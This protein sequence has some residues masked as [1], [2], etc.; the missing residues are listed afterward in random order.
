MRGAGG[1]GQL[2]TSSVRNGQFGRPWA[3]GA[4]RRT[5][6]A[7]RQEGK[8]ATDVAARVAMISC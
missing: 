8:N 1:E 4:R 6:P 5:S 7:Y 2:T 3:E